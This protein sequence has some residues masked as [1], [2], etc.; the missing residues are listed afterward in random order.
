MPHAGG[1]VIKGSLTVFINKMPAARM[2]DK[3][4]EIPGGPNQISS[5]C[6]SVVIGG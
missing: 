1:V 5:G 2:L 4:V 3:V 6:E